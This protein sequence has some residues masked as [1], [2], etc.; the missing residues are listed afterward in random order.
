MPTREHTGQSW[1][2]LTASCL[3]CGASR[4]FT[5]QQIARDGDDACIPM[6]PCEG[7]DRCTAMLCPACQHQCPGCGCWTCREHLAEI[8]A[9]GDSPAELRCEVC[10]AEIASQEDAALVAAM[11]R[12]AAD[13]AIVIEAGLT[14]REAAS[15]WALEAQGVGRVAS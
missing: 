1:S 15:L 11:A 3:H 4:T 9:E 2:D 8:P 14:E 12:E 5:R 6:V 7:S 13:D 10:R